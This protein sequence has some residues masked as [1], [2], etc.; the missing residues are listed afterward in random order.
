MSGSTTQQP[1]PPSQLEAE[2]LRRTADRMQDLRTTYQ[3]SSPIGLVLGAGVSAAHIA[4]YDDFVLRLLEEILDARDAGDGWEEAFVQHQRKRL[5]EGLSTVPPDIVATVARVSWASDEPLPGEF[6]DMALWDKARRADAVSGRAT[7]RSYAK[8]ASW[9][10][11]PTLNAVVTFC[12]DLEDGVPLANHKVGAVL[13]TNYDNLL[14]AAAHAKYR[15][16]K[17]FKPVARSTSRVE[18]PGR[19]QIPVIHIHGYVNYR[20]KDPSAIEGLVME[21]RDYYD[22]SYAPLGF[23]SYMTMAFFQRYPTLFIGSR[24]TDRNLRRLLR[25]IRRDSATGELPHAAYALM[26]LGEYTE[27][28]VLDMVTDVVLA[29]YGV[30]TIWVEDYGEIPDVLARVYSCNDDET[31]ATWRGLWDYSAYATKRRGAT[32]KRT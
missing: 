21:E 2:L 25:Q 7:S 20:E 28:H 24:L 17:L 5:E 31:A 10:A 26:R 15:K 23:G 30:Q 27:D 13:T 22:F 6:V 11:N 3:K 29:D 12:T 1:L 14:E 32:A 16:L 18:E 8:K 9:A 19:Q 4:T